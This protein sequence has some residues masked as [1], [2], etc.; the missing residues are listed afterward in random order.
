[1]YRSAVLGST[2]TANGVLSLARAAGRRCRC[3]PWPRRVDDRRD[4]PAR[5]DLADGVVERVR[6][7]EVAGLVQCDALG[8]VEA[9]AGGRSAVAAEAAET[10]GG[11]VG[12]LRHR[13]PWR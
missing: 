7:E 10:A 4:R 5:R 6:D 1:M 9:G 11:L 2:A 13:P 12:R 3:C 8:A